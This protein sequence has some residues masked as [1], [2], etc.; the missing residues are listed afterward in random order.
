MIS[1]VRFKFW[2]LA[3]NADNVQCYLKV[4]Y[5]LLKGQRSTKRSTYNDV[6]YAL[7]NSYLDIVAYKL[8]QICSDIVVYSLRNTLQST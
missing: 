4:L 8:L 2:H 5:G 1:T 3:N 7:L 6:V